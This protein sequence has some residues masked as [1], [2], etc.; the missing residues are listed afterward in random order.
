[1]SPKTPTQSDQA[2]RA[3]RE[4]YLEQIQGCF[5]TIGDLNNVKTTAANING[6]CGKCGGCMLN[7]LDK[8][9]VT[10][11]TDGVPALTGTFNKL[12]VGLKKAKSKVTGGNKD[13]IGDTGC[14][15]CEMRK[16]RDIAAA[17]MTGGPAQFTGYLAAPIP[18]SPLGTAF[19]QGIYPS[20]EYS[21]SPVG[22][23]RSDSNAPSTQ[24]TGSYQSNSASVEGTSEYCFRA[25]A[26][27]A[28]MSSVSLSDRVHVSRL[29][30]DH[31][32]ACFR[33]WALLPASRSTARATLSVSPIWAE[34]WVSPSRATRAPPSGIWTVCA[35]VSPPRAIAV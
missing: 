27:Q 21:P 5:E 2:Q 3:L 32:S 13:E 7:H 31:D 4:L 20:Q 22:S 12:S 11:P 8:H 23:H 18:I 25:P 10:C 15:L 34:S 26:R 33:A 14:P 28:C 35:S 17:E 6:P 24:G 19:E 9:S 29:F 30:R 1:M 16:Q